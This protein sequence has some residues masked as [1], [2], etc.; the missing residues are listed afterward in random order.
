MRF[1]LLVDAN[2]Q[3]HNHFQQQASKA[4]NISLTLRNWLICFYIVEF[5]Q[6]GEDRP[7]YGTELLNR[8]ALQLNIK[9]LVAAELSRCRQFY[10][11]YPQILG[12]VTQEFKNL[13]PNQ[14]LEAA[15][16]IPQ[17]GTDSMALKT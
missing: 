17:E 16:Q 15:T 7:V 5:E 3:V 4:I 14:I 10:N 11:R 8:L 9:G 6:K 12:S 13:M 2:S 1:E